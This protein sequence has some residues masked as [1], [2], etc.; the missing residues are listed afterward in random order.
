MNTCQRRAEFVTF[1][2]KTLR[3]TRMGYY[4]EILFQRKETVQII[5]KGLLFCVVF[6]MA[7]RFDTQEGIL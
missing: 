4:N 7:G 3:S 5:K 2:I 1:E 6:R